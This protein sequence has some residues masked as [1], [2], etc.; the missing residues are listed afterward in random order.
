MDQDMISRQ[1]Q[2]NKMAFNNTFNS[3]TIIQEQM[4]RMVRICIDKL[5]M[6]PVEGKKVFLDWANTYKKVTQM[7]LDIYSHDDEDGQQ[8]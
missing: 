8:H 7:S 2:I 3:L 4:E 6:I 1:L 5:P